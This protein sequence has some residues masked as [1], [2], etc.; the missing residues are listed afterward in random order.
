MRPVAPGDLSLMP[1]RLLGQSKRVRLVYREIRLSRGRDG[2]AT[3]DYQPITT[4]R[5][6]PLGDYVNL[7]V[8]H[9]YVEHYID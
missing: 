9:E 3:V 5:D 7:R 2:K 8:D 4:V 6:G 1:G